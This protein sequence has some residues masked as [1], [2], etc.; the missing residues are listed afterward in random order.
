[1]H[2]SG[3]RPFSGG[4]LDSRVNCL[5]SGLPRDGKRVARHR[6]GSPPGTWNLSRAMAQPASGPWS[7]SPSVFAAAAPAASIL[8]CGTRVLD[9][10]NCDTRLR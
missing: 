2:D 8:N 7:G 1:M 4:D 10:F 3:A 5:G 9:T 6:V